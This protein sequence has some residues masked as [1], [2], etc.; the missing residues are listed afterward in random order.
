MKKASEFKLFFTEAEI[1]TAAAGWAIGMVTID[2]INA[3]VNDLLWP[4]ILWSRDYWISFANEG[5]RKDTAP[6]ELLKLNYSHLIKAI[7][8]WMLSVLTVF[9]VIHLL[10]KR[11]LM[12]IF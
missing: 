8:T 12:R 11:L 4:L 1:I 10:L 2:L 6:P 9:L 5:R 3:F 7:I